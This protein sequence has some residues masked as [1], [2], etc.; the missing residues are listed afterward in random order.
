MRAAH[1]L[2]H[3]RLKDSVARNDCDARVVGNPT[4]A[5]LPFLVAPTRDKLVI[6]HKDYI[7]GMRFYLLLPQLLRTSRHVTVEPPSEPGAKDVSY[8]ANVCRHCPGAVCDRHLIHAH[9]C[10]SSK[11]KIR[12]R[13]D[14]VKAARTDTGRLGTSMCVWTRDSA[15]WG[16]RALRVRGGGMSSL[17]TILNT[18]TSGT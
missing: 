8:Q 10:N 6:D 12:D 7:S 16:L 11:A 9:A 14:L 18:F 17:W 13:H 2:A 1:G 3:T 5:F 15:R 4:D